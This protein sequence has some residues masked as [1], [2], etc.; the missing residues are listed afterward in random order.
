MTENTGEYFINDL[1][2]AR[3][4]SE[5]GKTEIYVGCPHLTKL[6]LSGVSLGEIPRQVWNDRSLKILSINGTQISEI[7]ENIITLENLST[8]WLDNNML[9]EIPIF[10]ETLPIEYISIKN[11]PLKTFPTF[12][13]K[14]RTLRTIYSDEEQV[15]R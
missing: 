3:L 15:R 7:P 13:F 1:L 6:T 9:E 8:I 11:N 2:S 4:N 14:I 5:T 10:L 12:L